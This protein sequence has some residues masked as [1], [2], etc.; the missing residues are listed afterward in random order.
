MYGIALDDK[1]N[2]IISEN[3]DDYYD[4]INPLIKGGNYG[5]PTMQP[6]NL[7]PELADPSHSITPLRSYWKTIAPTQAIYY[8]GD[9]YPELKGK[10]IVGSYNNGRLY[11]FDL[12]SNSTIDSNGIPRLMRE[13]K[14]DFAGNDL[15]PAIALAQ[16]PSGDI[17][18]GG[19]YM[20]KL[21]S[22]DF[23]SKKP[24]MAPVDVQLLSSSSSQLNRTI[25]NNN[26]NKNSGTATPEY[27]DSKQLSIDLAGKKI[28]LLLA[29]FMH[30]NTDSTDNNASQSLVR[31]IS[32]GNNNITLTVTI[33]K[34][35]LDGINTVSVSGQSSTDNN[36]TA[37]SPSLSQQ[38]AQSSYIN[39]TADGNA[40]IIVVK[41]LKPTSTIQ[42]SILGTSIPMIGNPGKAAA[43]AITTTSDTDANYPAK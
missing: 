36:S 3:G 26:D 38:L 9:K 41:N 32:S 13:I 7:P 1:G 17:Y 31:D 2:G 8:T 39:G 35:L 5:Y 18:Y 12:D 10:Y 24:F 37:P 42:V 6:P 34:I 14:L 28:S 29:P 20:Y 43:V 21:Q 19:Y 11:V 22:I 27:L 23:G 4:E 25:I 30:T 16:S 15:S 33:P 40:T